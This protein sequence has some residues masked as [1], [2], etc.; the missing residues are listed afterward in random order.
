[1][2]MVVGQE[3]LL[4]YRPPQQMAAYIGQIPSTSSVMV[5]LPYKDI[6]AQE[7]SGDI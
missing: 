3:L 5:I 6:L 1:M 4:Y 2:L 7:D